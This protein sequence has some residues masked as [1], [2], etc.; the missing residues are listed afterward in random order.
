MKKNKI[1]LL[2]VLIMLV[3]YCGAVVFVTKPDT[4]AFS[5]ILGDYNTIS[6]TNKAQLMEEV[7]DMIDGKIDAAVNDRIVPYVDSS[8]DTPR[9]QRRSRLW[10]PSSHLRRMPS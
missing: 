5:G 2:T 6:G 7:G 1:I 9:F 3:L 10:K 4:F 8:V